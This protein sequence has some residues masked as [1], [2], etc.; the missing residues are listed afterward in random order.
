[1]ICWLIWVDWLLQYVKVLKNIGMGF[2]LFV[3]KIYFQVCEILAN[4]LCKML[5]RIFHFIN[6]LNA[7]VSTLNVNDK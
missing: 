4:V 3:V 1:M 6:W 7:A 2:K 5:S